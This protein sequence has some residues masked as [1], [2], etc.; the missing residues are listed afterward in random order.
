MQWLWLWVRKYGVTDLS[1]LASLVPL[2]RADD[3][4][5]RNAPPNAPSRERRDRLSS[6]SWDGHAF[7]LEFQA[8]LCLLSIF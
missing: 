4:I 5:A 7:E 2:A 6:F 3:L 1:R 8:S